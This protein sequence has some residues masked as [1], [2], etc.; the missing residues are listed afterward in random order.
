LKHILENSYTKQ[1][2]FD[3]E[4]AIKELL[5]LYLVSNLELID[6]VN[7]TL[8]TYKEYVLADNNLNL[9]EKQKECYRVQTLI[10]KLNVC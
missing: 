9:E 8:Y 3:E 4:K 2:E 7:A 1:G 5:D 10:R 6:D